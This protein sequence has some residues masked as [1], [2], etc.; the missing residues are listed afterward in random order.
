[1]H[2][3]DKQ[4]NI[5]QFCLY[6]SNHNYS[7]L[8]THY[9]LILYFKY[10]FLDFGFKGDAGGVA[11]LGEE[12]GE[13]ALVAGDVALGSKFAKLGDVLLGIVGGIREVTGGR[14]AIGLI[15]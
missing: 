6:V 11:I 12:D 15:A 13:H 3:M 2:A 14:I 10:C 9:S 1:M 7:L 4:Q 8:I 5:G